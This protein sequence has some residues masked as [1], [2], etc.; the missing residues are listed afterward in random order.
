M[1]G[2]LSS[3]NSPRTPRLGQ[4]AENHFLLLSLSASL[5]RDESST[6]CQGLEA[7][8]QPHLCQ[9][10]PGDSTLLGLSFLFCP[11]TLQGCWGKTLGGGQRSTLSPCVVLG[12][13][14]LDHSF[15]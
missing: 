5:P 14:Q 12:F 8:T 3:S 15:H 9:S 1:N 7:E 4:W 10:L 11:T 6:T 2:F 13:P